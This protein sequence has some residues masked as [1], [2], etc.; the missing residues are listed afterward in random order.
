[1]SASAGVSRCRCQTLQQSDISDASWDGCPVGQ[2]IGTRPRSSD[3]LW[4][5]QAASD[6]PGRS[7]RSPDDHDPRPTGN[8]MAVI[9]KPAI[10]GPAPQQDVAALLRRAIPRRE[11][12]RRDGRRRAVPCARTH[13]SRWAAAR[14]RSACR[15]WGATVAASP[16]A[17]KTAE[18]RRAPIRTA[19][20]SFLREWAGSRTRSSAARGRTARNRAARNRAAR[21]RAATDRDSRWG[22]HGPAAGCWGSAA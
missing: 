8:P 14:S 15:R 18:K 11:R 16:G 2:F 3:H 5:A 13:R 1:M 4:T 7:S 19:G 22:P 20:P 17:R 9:R 10:R 12:F 21:N 6:V